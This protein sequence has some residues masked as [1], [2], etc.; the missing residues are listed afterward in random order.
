MCHSQCS[1]SPR[2]QAEC[3]VAVTGSL[4]QEYAFVRSLVV[5]GRSVGWW[6]CGGCG[7]CVGYV[8]C[9]MCG[10]WCVCVGVVCGVVGVVCDV[11]CVWDVCGGGV[12]CGMWMCG[13]GM[14][15]GEV[16]MW[17]GEVGVE[18]GG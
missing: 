15:C 2:A 5:S 13:V 6:G 3:F 18:C 8:V 9:G 17:C 16:G 12:G 14:W 10:M 11:W 4:L 7:M 1:A